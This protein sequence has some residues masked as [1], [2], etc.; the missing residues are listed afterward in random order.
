MRTL[1]SRRMNV[2]R[3]L[4]VFAALICP[5][6]AALI[7]AIS[8]PSQTAAVGQR[9]F[10]TVTISGVVA[11]VSNVGAFDLHLDFDPA[12]LRAVNVAFGPLL[13]NPL[14]LEALS[15]FNLLPS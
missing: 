8:P 9:V 2:S 5:A 4:S 10:E 3:L 14:A 13:G 1:E 7:L 12:V 6:K 15:S 11:G